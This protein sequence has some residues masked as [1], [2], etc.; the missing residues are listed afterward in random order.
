MSKRGRSVDNDETNLTT[1]AEQKEVMENSAQKFA[2]DRKIPLIK[3]NNEYGSP[4]Q[5]AA[6][7]CNILTPF[8]NKERIINSNSPY[9]QS[10]I[11][12]S[13]FLTPA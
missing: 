4:Q 7:L 10:H 3:F 12:R 11:N 5:S 13:Y 2:K 1:F 9:A 8:L 6:L